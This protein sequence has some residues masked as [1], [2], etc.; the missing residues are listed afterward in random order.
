MQRFLVSILWIFNWIV[1]IAIVIAYIAPYIDPALFSWPAFFSLAFPFIFIANVS[2]ALLWFFAR[3]YKFML[4]SLVLLLIGYPDIKT[5]LQVFSD[6][7]IPGKE[8][9]KVLTYN[10]RGFRQQGLKKEKEIARKIKAV[11]LK[12]SPEIICLQEADFFIPKKKNIK[13]KI[14][15]YKKIGKGENLIFTKL[16]IVKSGSIFDEKDV[17][18]G[19]F[20][21]VVFKKDTIRVYSV[22]LLS[23]GVSKDINDYEK[24]PE[25]VNSKRKFIKVLKKLNAGFKGRVTQ[26][27]KLKKSLETSPYPVILCG[28][29]NDPPQSYTYREL[30]SAG[31]KD[32]FVES[33]KGYGNTYNGYLP[34]IR[35]DYIFT[36][37][38][39][40]IYNYKVTKV[41]YSDHYP[42]SAFVVPK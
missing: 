29:M 21:D 13:F 24:N 34:N 33:G 4:L 30:I 36:S 17:K 3:K 19:V 2:F 28:D 11:I 10:V 22:Q 23:Y 38:D 16:K 42:V 27:F 7:K 25:K 39:F 35:I 9:I 26:T 6:K 1:A 15:G 20:A 37:D 31:L 32:A 14:K 5:H 40:D 18:F 12:N 8:G 41:K